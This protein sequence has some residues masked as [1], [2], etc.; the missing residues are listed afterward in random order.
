MTPFGAG[1]DVNTTQV[2]NGADV[3]VRQILQ[4]RPMPMYSAGSRPFPT[5]DRSASSRLDAS[6]IQA[7]PR[8]LRWLRCRRRLAKHLYR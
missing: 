7:G 2:A 5:A 1:A 6:V 3:L 4:P 8:W